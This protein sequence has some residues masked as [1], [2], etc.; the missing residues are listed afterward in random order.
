MHQQL[1]RDP[2]HALKAAAPQGANNPF[3]EIEEEE[4]MVEDENE[5]LD[6]AI[7]EWLAELPDDLE[8]VIIFL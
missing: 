5:T 2:S 8:V 7:P 4:E 6:V 3:A 1:F